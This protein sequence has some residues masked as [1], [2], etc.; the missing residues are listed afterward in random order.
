MTST[1]QYQFGPAGL[2]QPVL[3]RGRL[4]PIGA[5]DTNEA[6]IA[7]GQARVM[8]L[9]VDNGQRGLLRNVPV[10]GERVPLAGVKGK[11]AIRFDVTITGD[12]EGRNVLRSEPYIISVTRPDQPIEYWGECSTLRVTCV[13]AAGAKR[14]AAI[15]C[16]INADRKVAGKATVTISGSGIEYAAGEGTIDGRQ[17][18][19]RPA[20]RQALPPGRYQAIVLLQARGQR[21]QVLDVLQPALTRACETGSPAARHA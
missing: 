14:A 21:A 9:P 18:V 13:G 4:R 5:A 20:V 10:A 7:P 2:P 19:V 15:T 11:R 8:C 6:G 1:N 12:A 3:F 17:L 16:T